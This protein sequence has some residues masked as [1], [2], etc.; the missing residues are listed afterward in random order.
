MLLSTV[1]KN[2]QVSVATS[3]VSKHS[4]LCLLVGKFWF[5]SWVEQETRS[6]AQCDLLLV[7]SRLSKDLI[8]GDRQTQSLSDNSNFAI[9]GMGLSWPQ[10]WL[11]LHYAKYKGPW[12]ACAQ[13]QGVVK[14][15]HH[16]LLDALTTSAFA[17][18]D[19]GRGFSHFAEEIESLHA[20]WTEK[21]RD[22]RAGWL[23]QSSSFPVAYDYSKKKQKQINATESGGLYY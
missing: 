15:G 12:K 22:C 10:H 2:H 16:N 8:S 17:S 18:W 13:S 19:E 20:Q 7:H 11:P 9:M 23:L 4:T 5:Y 21:R 6:F 3:K 1:S 14:A